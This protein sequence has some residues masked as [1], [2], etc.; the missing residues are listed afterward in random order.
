MYPNMNFA[1]IW[2]FDSC[3]YWYAHRSGWWWDSS[4]QFPSENQPWQVW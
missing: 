1:V 4:N 2:M 3:V